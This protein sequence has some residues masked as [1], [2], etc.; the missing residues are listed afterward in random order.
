MATSAKV[1][2]GSMSPGELASKHREL[3]HALVGGDE[4]VVGELETLEAEIS[5]RDADTHAAERRAAA[6]RVHAEAL[7]AKA[8]ADAEAERLA[9]IRSRVSDLA[10]RESEVMGGLAAAVEALLAAEAEVRDWSNEIF[11]T[12]KQLD[13][14][15]LP[16]LAAA[17]APAAGIEPYVDGLLRPGRAIAGAH[18]TTPL[19]DLAAAKVTRLVAFVNT[20]R[21]PVPAPE[22]PS[23]PIRAA[24]DWEDL[25]GGASPDG[26]PAFSGADDMRPAVDADAEIAA[27]VRA[28]DPALFEGGEVT[29]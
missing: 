6:A 15:K 23:A 12:A 27:M 8:A 5:R 1:K 21:A 18:Y 16:L 22:A 9:A 29:R 3:S 4:S 7:E 24:I 17:D 13:T 11:D 25:T 20:D 26:L 2:P 14:G 19:T 10:A 28:S